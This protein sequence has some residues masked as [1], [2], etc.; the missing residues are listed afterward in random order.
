[1]LGPKLGSPFFMQTAMFNKG[2]RDLR[3]QVVFQGFGA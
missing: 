2:F 3:A 1:M